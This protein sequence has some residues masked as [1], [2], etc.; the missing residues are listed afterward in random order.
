MD[1][2]FHIF[3]YAIAA[4]FILILLARMKKKFSRPQKRP[5]KKRIK[6]ALICLLLLTVLVVFRN[7]VVKQVVSLGASFIIGAPVTIRQ[8]S[9]DLFDREVEIKGLNVYNPRGFAFEPFIQLNEASVEYNPWPLLRG[10]V[11]FELLYLDIRSVTL[12]ANEKGETNVDSLKLVKKIKADQKKKDKFNPFHF[13]IE[14]LRVNI[15]QL[16]QINHREHNEPVVKVF[17]YPARNKA[18]RNI[19]SPEQLVV[20]VILEAVGKA[21][22][23]SVALQAA[24]AYLGV[25]TLPVSI[26]G[27]MLKK[28]NTAG[29]W[30]IDSAQAR[31]ACLDVIERTGQLLADK[32]EEG[33]LEAKIHGAHITIRI[34]SMDENSVRIRVYA[35]KLFMS[36]K[37]LAAGVLY[38][39]A[40]RIES[41]YRDRRPVSLIPLPNRANPPE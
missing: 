8:L 20:L 24:G 22:L 1:K 36:R 15:E 37:E 23:R 38:Q 21:T 10:E 7:F 14:L 19:T 39:I 30:P 5:L 32:K 40:Q 9:V 26:A 29:E 27:I 2:F 11:Y 35:R 41:K 4:F 28:D 6:F 31:Q 16:V 18:F 3:F 25:N 13:R 34:T 12:I 33:I 17:E